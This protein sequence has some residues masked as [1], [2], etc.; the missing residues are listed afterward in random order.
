MLYIMLSLVIQLTFWSV[1]SYA[2]LLCN[3]YSMSERDWAQAANRLVEKVCLFVFG[4]VMNLS[5][6]LPSYHVWI[7]LD[8][9]Y[10]TSL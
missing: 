5:S 8:K 3:N 4:W 10:N 7:P 1:C 2:T 9:L 6:I